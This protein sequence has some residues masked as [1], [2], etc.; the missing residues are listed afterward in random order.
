M[1][2][3][4]QAVCALPS[5]GGSGQGLGIEVGQV[6]WLQAGLVWCEEG[7]RFVYVFSAAGCDE[8]PSKGV[9]RPEVDQ[10][11]WMEQVQW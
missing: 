1:P 5:D 11:V 6:C 3:V 9:V 4:A 10:R 8:Q 2:A 7:V